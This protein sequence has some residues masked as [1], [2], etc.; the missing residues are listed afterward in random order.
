MNTAVVFVLVALA[1]TANA[2]QFKHQDDIVHKPLGANYR[3]A[4]VCLAWSN[5]FDRHIF[6]QVFLEKGQYVVKN[7]KCIAVH[8]HLIHS[9]HFQVWTNKMLLP[10]DHLRT[11]WTL[12]VGTRTHTHATASSKYVLFV[13]LG[14]F[15]NQDEQQV[16]WCNVISIRTRTTPQTT[17]RYTTHRTPPIHPVHHAHT[18]THMRCHLTCVSFLFV[19]QLYGAGF[20]EG[21]LT[22][23]RIWEQYNNMYA[24]SLP[25]PSPSPPLPPP[26]PLLLSLPSPPPSFTY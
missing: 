25:L 22:M 17:P 18:Y 5:D 20:L 19:S 23:Q 24:P 15:K 6:L 16:W 11:A 12:L 7:G 8:E 9:V 10:M 14:C 1:I 4:S 3:E 21:A 2:V 13:R 26:F